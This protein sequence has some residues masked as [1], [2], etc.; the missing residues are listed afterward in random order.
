MDYVQQFVVGFVVGLSGAMIPGPLL[1]FTVSRTMRGNIWTPLKIIVGHMIIELGIVIVILV[2]L[3]QVQGSATFIAVVSII[4]RAVMTL[5]GTLTVVNAPKYALAD[6]PHGE[7][8]V[9]SARGDISGGAFLSAFNASFPL[10]WLTVG[11]AMIIG[12]WKLGIMGLAFFLAGHWL[13]DFGWYGVVG[14]GVV[15]G[16]KFL[17]RRI[18]HILLR[19]LGAGLMGFGIYFLLSALVG[20]TG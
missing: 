5:L 10:W 13:S 16:R 6:N 12:A 15:K 2:G 9:T 3:R 4:G 7:S 8:S 11:A 20:G 14:L 17:S 19:V 18:Y 1:V